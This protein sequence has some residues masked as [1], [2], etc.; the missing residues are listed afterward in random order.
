M[1]TF[2]ARADGLWSEN[3][4]W[5]TTTSFVMNS[6]FGGSPGTIH[7]DGQLVAAQFGAGVPFAITGNGPNDGFYLSTG[8]IESGGNTIISVATLPNTNTNDG[9]IFLCG[10]PGDSDDVYIDYT[11]VVTVDDVISNLQSLHLGQNSGGGS[12]IFNDACSIAV[13][14]QADLSADRAVTITNCTTGSLLAGGVDA[15][16]NQSAGAGT[17]DLTLVNSDIL[18]P[19]TGYNSLSIG[20]IMDDTSSISQ[21]RLNGNNVSITGGEMTDLFTESTGAA[22]TISFYNVHWSGAIA[23]EQDFTNVGAAINFT[24]C[25]VD[26]SINTTTS[27]S[28]FN[29]AGGTFNGNYQLNNAET[30]LDGDKFYGS[31]YNSQPTVIHGNASFYGAFQIDS[32]STI[33]EDGAN[34]VFNFYS[35]AILAPDDTIFGTWNIYNILTLQGLL[36]AA[37]VATINL[38]T[39]A[40]KVWPTDG[41][42]VTINYTGPAGGAMG[43]FSFNI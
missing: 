38:V 20:I 18:G 26:V 35:T 17:L 36:N 1:A 22:Y 2:N 43:N 33:G 16:F 39:S 24:D 25:L 28:S 19:I 10:V 31:F 14:D 13:G 27:I 41:G 32:T 4:T 9:I 3:S 34:N 5:V 23:G 6:N 8:A 30:E 7:L 40:A 12:L 37:S 11:Y 29:S 21:I 42:N 15:G